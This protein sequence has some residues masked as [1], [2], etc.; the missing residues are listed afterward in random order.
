M[1]NEFGFENSEERI[2]KWI[3][4][5]Y[6]FMYMQLCIHE[7]FHFIVG[8]LMKLPIHSVRI[9]SEFFSI[10]IGKIFISPILGSGYVEVERATLMQKPILQRWL[11]FEA[12][13]IGNLLASMLAKNFIEY[14]YSFIFGVIGSIYVIASNIPIFVGNDM[15][16]FL[17]L[18]RKK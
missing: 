11:F 1:D 7:I 4:L 10:H 15:W 6:V 2:M 16:N 9:G 12:G 17:A 3:M 14:E 18:S 13:S 8:F 5:I